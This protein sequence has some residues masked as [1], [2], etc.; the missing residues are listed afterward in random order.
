MDFEKIKCDEW[1]ETDGL[2]GFAS[3]TVSDRFVLAAEPDRI[4]ASFRLKAASK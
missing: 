4:S 1:L 2:G 3:G